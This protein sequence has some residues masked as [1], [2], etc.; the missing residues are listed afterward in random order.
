MV[1]LLLA[2]LHHPV[3][4]LRADHSPFQPPPTPAPAPA[5]AAPALEEEDLTDPDGL[6]TS[7]WLVCLSLPPSL[8]LSL[9][10]ISTVLGSVHTGGGSTPVLTAMSLAASGLGPPTLGL[11]SELCDA[12]LTLAASCL[13]VLS[14]NLVKDQGRASLTDAGGGL[15]PPRPPAPP[16]VT[17]VPTVEAAMAAACWVCELGLAWREE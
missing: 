8:S 12:S 2:G 6:T 10:G 14:S 11:V 5:P 9:C 4:F 13:L 7:S 16:A 3:I 17:V 1:A 15:G